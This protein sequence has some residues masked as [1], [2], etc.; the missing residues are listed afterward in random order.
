MTVMDRENDK[1]RPFDD[2]PEGEG[3]AHGS[4]QAA[5]HGSGLDPGN[6]ADQNDDY[7]DEFA[8]D[9]NFRAP[10]FLTSDRMIATDSGRLALQDD[11][12]ALPWLESGDDEEDS[13]S[14]SG[15]IIGFV[16]VGLAALAVIVGGIWWASHR[17]TDPELI[18]D[19]STIAAPETPYKEAPKDPGGKTFAGTGDSSFAVSEGQTPPTRLGESSTT[20]PKPSVDVDAKPAAS[21]AATKEAAP[22]AAS[23]GVA[24][25]VGAF[26]T[27]A[28]AETAWSRLQ[29]QHSVLAGRPHRVI[30]GSADIGTVFRL[31]AIAPDGSGANSLCSALKAAGQSCQV[32][33]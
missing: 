16:L 25:Q 28:S 10:E 22:S 31:Q 2:Q 30:Q 6:D 11:D 8:E 12:I 19:G 3:M 21:G 27:A 18:A 29:T 13:P 15:R 33:N 23:S 14:D 26:S 17:R 20:A 1:E 4:D 32:K 24:V 7:G 9:P 5:S